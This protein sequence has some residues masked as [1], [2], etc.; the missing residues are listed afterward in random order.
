MSFQI[1]KENA[2]DIW[3]HSQT[4]DL[5]NDLILST[6]F[7]KFTADIFELFSESGG[8]LRTSALTNI[9][10]IDETDAGLPETFTTALNLTTRLKALGYPFFNEAGAAGAVLSV[11]G[12]TGAVVATLNDYTSSLVNNTSIVSG[13]T[14]SDALNTLSGQVTGFVSVSG[15]PLVN[16]FAV[17]TDATTAKGIPQMTLVGGDF[18]MGEINGILTI[19]TL[20]GFSEI[21]ASNRFDF[22]TNE[23]IR[24]NT[25]GKSSATNFVPSS[26]G[27]TT[28][29]A[30]TQSGVIPVTV[31][32]S[33]AGSDGNISVSLG[34]GDMILADAQT[35]TGTKTFSVGTLLLDDSDSAFNLI[36]G[37]TSTITT[38]NKTLTFDVNDADRTL[39]FTSD[40]T[41]GGTNTGD[42]TI[43]L[44]GDVT[45]TGTSSFA[46]TIATNA[47][48]FPKM[49]NVGTS[50]I[51][52]RITGGTGNIES[53]SGTQATTL[54]DVFTTGLQGVVPAS[55]GGTT[56]FLRADNTWA[57]PGGGAQDLQS[58]T[59]IGNTST[60]NIAINGTGAANLNV[61]NTSSFRTA[62][63]FSDNLVFSRDSF[64]LTIQSPTL[65]ANSTLTIPDPTVNRTLPIS[66]NS[67][68]ADA[69]GNIVIAA[70]G[71]M[72]LADA[73]TNTGAK[74]F[75]DGT[76][77]L[78]NVANTFNGVFTN[79]NTADRTYTIKDSDG[80][81]AFLTDLGFSEWS[82]FTGTR[83]VND[84]LVL[85]GDYDDEGNG[86]KIT[87]NLAGDAIGFETGA[88]ETL[89]IADS[90]LTVNATLDVNG[91]INTIHTAT[92][93]N[94]H[95]LDIICDAAGFGDVKALDIVYTTGGLGTGE[96]DG[97]I[98]INIDESLA[99]G[100]EVFG[101]EV[102]T[103]DFGS[104]AVYAL[105]VGVEANVIFQDSGTFGNM[106][107]ALNI[108]VDVLAAVSSGGA[109][110]ISMFV[111][112][113]D[114]I[115]IGNAIIFDEM[116]FLIGTGASAAGINPVF[117]YSTGV[118]TWAAFTPTD[119]TNGFKNTGA[120]LWD[121]TD[122]AG[123]AIGTGSEFLIRITRT[124]NSLSTTPI[125]DTIQISSVLIYSWD[126]DGNLLV[127]S[128]D[129]GGTS[130]Q[131]IKGDGTLSFEGVEIGIACSDENTALTTGAAK[132]TFRTPFAMTLTEVRANVKTAPTG[133]VLTV[134]INETG[135]TILSTKITIDATEKTSETAAIPPIISNLSLSNDAEMTVDIDTIG[136]TIAGTGLKIWLIGSK[137]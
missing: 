109:G 12:R 3:R 48:T 105:K 125:V 73:Q 104:T 116:E 108:A 135:A 71:D 120:I 128:I 121:S 7:F 60:N 112:D 114:T 126:K 137:T 96:D 95:A 36:L 4:D 50:V 21:L 2:S 33:A 20:T 92:E 94:N 78:R 25:I 37:S 49:T 47:V 131:F 31:N 19:R 39:T 15:T 99:T 132:V 97:V 28:L 100:G 86:T 35:V 127:N 38:A 64:N 82:T 6:G 32:G 89:T 10:V 57:A 66:V 70:G 69:A 113:N 51:L 56:N 14:V 107:S 93:A 1:I 136:S 122:L 53:L 13:A 106:D 103:T 134:D 41:I 68:F 117:E 98:L 77:L 45:G 40:A 81:F 46:T 26:S 61:N 65:T 27:I 44:T 34:L 55:G 67:A 110:N 30:P 24:L 124:R 129:V 84:L 85:L 58:V 72:I 18:I 91:V 80:T 8:S 23:G 83:A 101:V 87:I 62:S 102:L 42:Q 90:L 16:Q 43:T 75:N 133:S 54:L 52:G 79:T 59:D 118:G 29:T 111:A 63:I 130:S 76:L 5:N 22:E 9:V 115:T 11:F 119:S 74:T 17:W 88:V 123:W